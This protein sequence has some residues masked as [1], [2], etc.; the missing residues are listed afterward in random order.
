VEI[1]GRKIPGQGYVVGEI[2]QKKNPFSFVHERTEKT[3]ED[4]INEDFYCVCIYAILKDHIH[5]RE[6]TTALS[7]LKSKIV[8][9]HGK[10]VQSFTIDTQESILFQ[11]ENPSFFIS[12]KCGNGVCRG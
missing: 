4:K 1:T 2:C 11:G 7:H 6:K 9:L 8:R 5:P 10:R 3:R 12:Y